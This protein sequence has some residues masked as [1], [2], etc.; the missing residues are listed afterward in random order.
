MAR[1]LNEQSEKGTDWCYQLMPV[2]L[3]AVVN[4]IPKHPWIESRYHYHFQALDI[5]SHKRLDDA[6]SIS[7]VV[8][9]L[10][11]LDYEN[12][13]SRAAKWA[14]LLK[15][16]ES[17]DQESAKM[18]RSDKVLTDMEVARL[19]P[20]E[21]E[22]VTLETLHRWD[23]IATL[24]GARDEGRSEGINVGRLE[25]DIET[26]THLAASGFTDSKICQTLGWQKD[27][28]EAV[29][30]ALTPPNL[31]DNDSQ[32]DTASNSEF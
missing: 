20:E 2:S 18:F 10:F 7:F 30:Q 11:N 19:S 5:D 14:Y 27:R 1:E 22:M 16:L 31:N 26:Y 9:P 3:I 32:I 23:R 8:L 29:K 24:E 28:L 6:W 12:C 15:N 4:F 25:S 21:R 17:L 13:T